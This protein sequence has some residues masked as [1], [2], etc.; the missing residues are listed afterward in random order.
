MLVFQPKRKFAWKACIDAAE[1]ELLGENAI[2]F[3]SPY[4][5][6][7]SYRQLYQLLEQSPVVT[8]AFMN[9]GLGY[10]FIGLREGLLYFSDSVE[11]I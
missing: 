9:I 1:K 7:K 8:E 5:T 4:R 3:G 6:D 11:S 10:V 2:P